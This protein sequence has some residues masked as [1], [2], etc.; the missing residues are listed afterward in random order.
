MVAKTAGFCFGVKRAV[1][2]ACE[3]AASA[4]GPVFTLGP[5]IHNPQ[6][7]EWLKE[8]GVGVVESAR[9]LPQGAWVIVRSHGIP[10]E[11]L[12]WLKESG[13]RVVD[14]TCPFVKKA[15]EIVASLVCEDF[16]VVIVGDRDH[17]E[18]KALVSYG[19]GRAVI[20]PELPEDGGRV[21]FVAQTT[22][23][24]DRYLECVSKAI[25]R[26]SFSEVRVHNTVCRS[27]AERQMECVNIAKVSDVLVVVGGRNSANTR[28]LVDIGVA[29]G[30]ETHHI[31]VAEE[32]DPSWF[33]GK[34]VIG[35]TAGA[36]TPDWI[37][38]QVV[39]EVRRITGGVVDGGETGEP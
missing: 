20:Y 11:L 13:F 15:Q 26:L 2:I 32:L 1:R 23:I 16:S 25:E 10:K 5:L 24:M 33:L 28:K 27:T 22:Q 4:D 35:I 3:T 19:D 34:R 12:N 39:E 36:S 18:V 9:D 29:S 37:I 14:A 7:V 17:P 30:R 8:K 6:V 31:E 38:S 21:G